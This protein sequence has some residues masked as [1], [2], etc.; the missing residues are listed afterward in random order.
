MG[1]RIVAETI[2]GILSNDRNSYLNV[3]PSWRPSPG[4]SLMGHLLLESG[5]FVP[6]QFPSGP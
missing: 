1:G 6:G 2:L 4:P 5:A 3:S